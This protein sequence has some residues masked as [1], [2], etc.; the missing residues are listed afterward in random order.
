MADED[1][2]AARTLLRTRRRSSAVFHMHLAVEKTLKALICE[3]SGPDATPNSHDLPRLLTLA[4]VAPPP[5]LLSL[6]ARLSPYGVRA[7]Y[8]KTDEGYTDVLC[9]EL[10]SGAE[11]AMAWLRQKL[12]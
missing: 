5:S 7:R 11:G 12:T 9:R 2:A 3:I 6:L 10:L 1:R 8:E 4:N